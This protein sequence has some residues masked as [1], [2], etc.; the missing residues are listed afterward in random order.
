MLVISFNMLLGMGILILLICYALFTLGLAISWHRIKNVNTSTPD[1]LPRTKFT[2]IVPVR[3]EEKNIRALIEDLEAQNYPK[4]LYEILIMND[5][6]TDG[7]AQLVQAKMETSVCQLRL[8]DLPVHASK[9]P[10]KRAIET[11]V[12]LASGQLIT[13]TDGDCRV[14]PFWLHS[15]AMAY[16]TTN[17]KLLSGPVTFLPESSLTDHLQTIEFA[18]LVASGACS[19]SEGYPSMCNGANLTYEKEAFL[20]VGGFSGVDHLASGDDEFLMHK[21]ANQFPGRLGF[22]KMQEA[23]VY[24]GAHQ[25]WPSFFQQRKRWGSKWKHYKSLTPKVLAIFIFISNFSLLALSILALT[26]FVPIS[27]MLWGWLLKCLAEWIFL[28]P[29]L[30]FFGKTT[31]LP[32]LILT[33]LVYPFYV[34]YFGLAAQD[35]HY[36]WKDRQLS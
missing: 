28:I 21:I 7:T 22:V 26:G 36:I 5:G 27:I 20:S 29:V 8:I 34:S 3:N 15:L 17:H 25:T 14:G 16:E 30:Q 11:G 19:L 32:Y 24:T 9:S 18:S 23:I 2:I 12:N 6:S 4:A 1:S 13:T 33:Q 10:K 31:S 35:K